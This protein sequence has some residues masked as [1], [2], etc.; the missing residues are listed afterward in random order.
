MES[1]L[2]V[3]FHLEDFEALLP[4]LERQ[5][6]RSLGLGLELEKPRFDIGV[7]FS[8]TR[9]QYDATVLLGALAEQG[10]GRRVVGLTDLDLFISIFTFV[11]GAGQL[12]GRAAVVSTRRLRPESFGLPPDPA[13]LEE[14][15]AKEVVH[16]LG[17]TFGLRHCLDAGCAM[18]ASSVAD[19]VDS[20]GADLRGDCLTKLRAARGHT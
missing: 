8:G 7:S 13:L 5:L 20:R 4:A 16:E 14:R 11:L 15:V 10:G 17:H 19:Q 12:G 9:N 1:V 18:M 6:R 3:P 2:L